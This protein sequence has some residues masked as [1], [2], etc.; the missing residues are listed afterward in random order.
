[1][2]GVKESEQKIEWNIKE[3]VIENDD[4]YGVYISEDRI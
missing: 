1:M 2:Q 3:Q 4:R